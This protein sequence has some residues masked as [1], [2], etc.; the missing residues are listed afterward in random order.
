MKAIIF[1]LGIV[2]VFNFTSISQENYLNS[3]NYTAECISTD[4]VDK[5]QIFVFTENDSIIIE[6]VLFNQCCPQFELRIYEVIN[7]TL[8]VTFID[9]ST[10]MCDCMCNFDFRINAGKVPVNVTKVNFNGK[11]YDLLERRIHSLI[12]IGKKWN[13]LNMIPGLDN[14]LP[15]IIEHKIESDET[16]A[17]CYNGKFYHE[18][19]TI[20]LVNR[21]TNALDTIINYIREENG[22]VYLYDNSIAA[23]NFCSEV[24]LYDFTLNV[25]DT[26]IVGYDLI[27]YVAIEVSEIQGRRSIK[28]A[29]LSDYPLL[30]MDI[31]FSATWVEGVGDLR[32]LYYSGISLYLVGTYNVLTCCSVN[33]TLI[34]QNPDYPNC[35]I[36]PA[37][38]FFIQEGKVWTTVINCT[39][40]EDTS[41]KHNDSI[42]GNNMNFSLFAMRYYPYPGIE[43]EYFQEENGRVYYKQEDIKFLIYDFTKEAGDSV[44]VGNPNEIQYHLFVDSVKYIKYADTNKRKTLY[45]SGDFNTTWIEGIGDI[46]SPLGYWLPLPDNGCFSDFAC[47]TLNGKLIYQNPKYPNCGI[48]TSIFKGNSNQI[49]IYPNPS[50]GLLKISGFEENS[51]F[52]YFIYNT[53]GKL[54]QQGNIKPTLNLN[55][56]K[57]LYM[58]II[59]SGDKIVKTEKLLVK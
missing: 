3:N 58:F 14:S 20:Y 16:Q 6:G 4:F 26:V 42:T 29:E 7:S 49:Q 59:N 2:I 17:F 55:L 53:I 10:L 21:D 23:S 18:V 44:K 37:Y 41:Y 54:I 13:E 12:E 8:N 1:I 39:M 35:G 19:K 46:N 48:N 25:G 5:T 51:N 11:Y 24:L 28:L 40:F 47:C 31:M 50:N 9:T 32:G 33:D 27:K 45:L 56:S 57:G 43:N 22:K 38:Q 52:N 34:Y 15:N 30:H 36:R